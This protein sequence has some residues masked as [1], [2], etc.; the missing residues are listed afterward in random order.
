MQ[1][2]EDK[3][4]ADGITVP[5]IG[6]HNGTFNTGVGALD[7]DGPDSYPQGFDCSNPTRWNGVPDISYDHPAGKPLYTP[8]F[9]GGSF[10]PWG[11]PGYDK[12]APA[13]QRPV[14]ERVLQA[15]HRRRRDGP[16][17]LHDLRRHLVGLA[18]HPAGLHL[19]RLRRG[20][21]RGP[22]ARPEV[23]RGQADRLL[24]AG[25]RAADQ[26]R[27][28]AAAPRRP[29]ATLVDTARLNPDTGTQFHTLRHSDSTSTA[30]DT[31]HL[32][33]DLNATGGYTYDDTDPAL[34][35]TGTWTHVGAEQS[36]TAGDYQRTE[37][38]S[39]RAGDHVD[40][41]FTGTA[42]RFVTS[43]TNNHGIADVYLDGTKVASVD[44]YSAATRARSSPTR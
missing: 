37:S 19:L 18:R 44:T 16:E 28:P 33:L 38:F 17:L 36:Y 9:Q 34:Q 39:N 12:C 20:H 3:A 32:A 43:K 30:I 4:R 11:G 7:V 22:A 15:E 13:H 26:D 21:H 41:P 6:N 23:R 24:H 25:G 29:T 27:Q 2:L 8:E 40:V 42:V 31:T 35:Y 1:H 5:L 10:D 14:R